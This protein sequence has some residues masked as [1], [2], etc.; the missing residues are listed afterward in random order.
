MKGADWMVERIA[1]GEADGISSDL[2]VRTSE[3]A[4]KY[5]GQ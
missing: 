4:L 3:G 5:N 1:E 2:F